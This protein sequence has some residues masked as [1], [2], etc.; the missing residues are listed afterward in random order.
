MKPRGA[1]MEQQHLPSASVE[2]IEERIYTVRGQRALQYT[3]IGVASRWIL[4]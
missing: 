2:R 1:F 4:Q 3:N